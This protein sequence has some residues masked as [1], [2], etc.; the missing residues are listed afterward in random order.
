[1]NVC[2][3]GCLFW[4]SH[5]ISLFSREK[6]NLLIVETLLKTLF[7][8]FTFSHLN[9]NH[10]TSLFLWIEWKLEKELKKTGKY[11][12]EQIKDVNMS[13]GIYSTAFWIEEASNWKRITSI[14]ATNVF[15][16]RRWVC[17]WFKKL[18]SVRVRLL[19]VHFHLSH[20]MSQFLIETQAHWQVTLF[21]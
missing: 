15:F 1:M 9:A 20:I 16:S 4:F 3:C 10:P 14:F 7:M 18:A 13:D 2:R 8:R 21:H 5:D 19:L 11:L 12:W 6:P 17:V